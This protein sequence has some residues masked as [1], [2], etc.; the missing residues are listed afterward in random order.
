MRK[1]IFAILAAASLV[2][3]SN[4]E[5]VNVA[6]KEA[7]AFDNAFVDNS[8]RSV[9]DPSFTNSNLFAD[10]QVYGYVN[11]AKLFGDGARVAKDITNSALSSAWK[12]SHTQYWIEGGI[13]DFQAVAP[14]TN[15][16]WTA[17]AHSKDGLTLS[18]TNNGTTDLLYAKT[19]PYTAEASGNPTVAFNFSHILSK[20]KFSFE[21]GYNADNTKIKVH[22]IA[23][24]NAYKTGV[25]AL[26]ADKPVW[27]EQQDAITG[28]NFGVAT[29]NQATTDVKENVEDTF[30]FGITR[31]SQNELLLIPADYTTTKLAVTFKYDVVVGGTTINTFTV[32]PAVPVNLLPGNAYD[33][34][35]VIKP[36]Q[37]IEFTVNPLAGWDN[38]NT[39]DDLTDND[40]NHTTIK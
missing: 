27:R 19:T 6:D 33:F 14:L 37:A 22:S 18:F 28:F 8:T 34:K 12:Y 31:E 16:A 3:C 39:V 2:A 40:S 5:F 17:S 15:G 1:T 11:G 9:V 32:T 7:I 36:G 24:T 35:A 13:Y 10:F 20:V 21:N 23:I 38:G 26:G 4:D 25:V 30:G 29:D